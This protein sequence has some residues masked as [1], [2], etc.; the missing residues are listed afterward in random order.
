[1]MGKVETQVLMTWG[2]ARS[3]TRTLCDDRETHLGRATPAGGLPH[4]HFL[5]LPSQW[6]PDCGQVCSFPREAGKVSPVFA[7]G[8]LAES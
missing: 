3:D 1:M 8:W 4:I 5:L 7:P 6:N 2:G